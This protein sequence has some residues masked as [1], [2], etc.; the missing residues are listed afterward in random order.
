[1]GILGWKPFLTKK[2]IGTE[3][4]KSG[5]NTFVKERV[6]LVDVLASHYYKMLRLSNIKDEDYQR[7][8]IVTYLK[9]IYIED[10]GFDS[11]KIIFVFDGDLH[12]AKWNTKR[13][14]LGSSIVDQAKIVCFS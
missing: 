3:I 13:Q 10:L 14:R 6:V 11:K 8:K 1:M 7:E 5:L 4:T 9:K 2:G 12:S